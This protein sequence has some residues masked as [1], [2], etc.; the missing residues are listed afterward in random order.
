MASFSALRLRRILLV[1]AIGLSALPAMAQ[2][3][4]I[5]NVIT[6]LDSHGGQKITP[7]GDP[8]GGG[9]PMPTTNAATSTPLTPTGISPSSN[10]TLVTGGASQT[11]AAANVCPNFIYINNATS[12]AGEG[13]IAAAESIWVNITGDTS[14]STGGGSSIEIA[15]GVTQPFVAQTVAI[16][17]IAA[18]TGHKINAV[19]E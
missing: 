14:T 1:S 3:S 11:L 19:C 6:G 5:P 13:G 15:P 7:V 17:W 12:T 4:T 9:V 10:L 18:T 8:S 2:Q 16:T